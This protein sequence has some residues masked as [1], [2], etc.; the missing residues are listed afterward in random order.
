MK[1]AWKLLLFAMGLLHVAA[2]GFAQP[3]SCYGT[4]NPTTPANH[5]ALVVTVLLICHF[6][7]GATARQ[8]T[9][10]LGLKALKHRGSSPV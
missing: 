5:A 6:H 8:L 3:R 1:P 4:C 2:L 9:V 10:P 7:C